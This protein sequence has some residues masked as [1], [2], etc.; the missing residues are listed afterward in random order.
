[1]NT[2]TVWRD[3]AAHV[4]PHLSKEQD[5]PMKAGD[6]VEVGTP[7]GG[8][9]GNPFSREPGKVADDVQ[10]GYYTREAARRLFGVELAQDGSVDAAATAR[11][12]A[13]RPGG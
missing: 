10:L 8:G 6:R 1:M 4:P 13:G 5:I 7:G 2:V 11:L 12:R 9:Y 3:G